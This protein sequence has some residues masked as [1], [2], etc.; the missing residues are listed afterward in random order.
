MDYVKFTCLGLIVMLFL[1]CEKE[2]NTAIQPAMIMGSWVNPVLDDTLWTY[3]KS[4]NLK[5]NEYGL[6]FEAGN[7]FIERKNSGWCATPPIA[8]GDFE[9]KWFKEDSIIDI[10]V[11]FWGGTAGYRWKVISLDR[12][13]LTIHKVSENY[14]PGDQ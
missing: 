7:V 6:S 13:K 8:Y 1:S 2:Q 3:D 11:D 10:S 9:G 5:E 14:Q 4:A 12:N